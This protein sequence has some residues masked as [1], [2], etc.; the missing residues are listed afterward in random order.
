MMDKANLDLLRERWS[1]DMI[2][3][4]V[5]ALNQGLSIRSILRELPQTRAPGISSRMLDL[6]G[7]DLS[8]QNL[9]GPWKVQGGMRRRAG[10]NL[11]SADLSGAFLQ[12]VILPNADLRNARL[13]HAVLQ[14]AEL[15]HA[16]LSGADLTGADLTGAW[17]LFTNFRGAC[18]TETQLHS[19]RNLG[20]LDFD[21]HAFEL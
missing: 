2:N 18:V 5:L 12:W 20:Q 6:R 14:D 4:I 15:I 7:I 13:H 21:Y 1:R 10:V 8:H 9:R 16:N 11:K 3:S 17:L 19:R